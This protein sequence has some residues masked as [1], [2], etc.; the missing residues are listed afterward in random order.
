[1]FNATYY[2]LKY[3]RKV[4][5]FSLVAHEESVSTRTAI[6]YAYYKCLCGNSSS[7]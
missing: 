4:V 7:A 2:L 1:M 3:L 5:V 6:H